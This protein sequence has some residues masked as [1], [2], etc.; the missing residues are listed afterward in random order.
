[1]SAQLFGIRVV[2]YNATILL[3]LVAPITNLL[4]LFKPCYNVANVKR[5]TDSG[6]G[7]DYHLLRIMLRDEVQ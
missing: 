6:N 7:V 2:Y 3:W 4:P 5:P 1:M